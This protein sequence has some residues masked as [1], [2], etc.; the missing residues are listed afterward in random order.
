MSNGSLYKNT[1]FF[2]YH[3]LPQEIEKI[4]KDISVYVLNIPNT[5]FLLN[6]HKSSWLSPSE[7]VETTNTL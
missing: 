4:F 1:I 6:K 3:N 5:L 7:E 2:K